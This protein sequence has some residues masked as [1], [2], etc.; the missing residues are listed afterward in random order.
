MTPARLRAKV[1]LDRLRWIRE[2][3]VLIRA[4]P[5]GSLDE[6]TADPRTP[7]AAES[8]LRRCLE[9]LM[10]LGRHILAKGFARPVPEFKTIARELRSVG[11]VDAR[12]EELLRLMAGYRNRL[13]HFYQEVSAEELYE[14]CTMGLAD[15]EYVTG[16]M[17]AWIKEHPEKMDYSL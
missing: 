12:N 8:Y 16:M 3:L 1:V 6:F 2:M 7:A 10:D 5:L 4:L 9:A 13:T 17:E 11:V 14:I 15:I